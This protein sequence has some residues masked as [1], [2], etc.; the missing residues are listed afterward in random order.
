MQNIYDLTLNEL[1]EYFVS[2]DEKPFRASQVYE[3]L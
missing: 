2:I 1:E 3:G